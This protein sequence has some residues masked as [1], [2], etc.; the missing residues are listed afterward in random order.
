VAS[1]RWQLLRRHTLDL[2]MAIRVNDVALEHHFDG[3]STARF[4]FFARD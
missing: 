3:H 1:W 2:A 4:G